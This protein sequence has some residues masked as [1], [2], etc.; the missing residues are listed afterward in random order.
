MV[1]LA[2]II[3]YATHMGFLILVAKIIYVGTHY[4]ELSFGMLLLLT[5]HALLLVTTSVCQMLVLYEYLMIIKQ[6]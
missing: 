4:C 6:V 5:V 2:Q 1:L 3:S